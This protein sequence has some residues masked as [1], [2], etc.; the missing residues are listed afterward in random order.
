MRKNHGRSAAATTNSTSRKIA[1]SDASASAKPA[2][3]DARSA[4]RRGSRA[5]RR[6]GSP[7]GTRARGTRT[8]AVIAAKATTSVATTE[9][10]TSWRGKRTLRMI[11]AFS[12]MLRAPRLQRR[13]EEDPGR[14]AAEQEQPVVVASRS[15]AP[16]RAPRRRRGRRASARPAARASTRAR[17]AIPCTSRAG[18]AGRGCR[19]ARGAAGGRRRRSSSAIVGAGPTGTG[20]VDER[21]DYA[22]LRARGR[23]RP[24]WASGRRRGGTRGGRRVPP[25]ARVTTPAS[26]VR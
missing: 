1:L 21:P 2:D 14:Q 13:R 20:I 16:S 17:A 9:S 15:A 6:R 23:E 5:R 3:E 25:R 11:G 22:P 10:G 4:P 18:R 24:A 7:A 19:T 8:I 26:S 12:T